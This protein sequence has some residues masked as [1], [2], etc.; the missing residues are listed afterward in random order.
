LNG[1]PTAFGV[2]VWVLPEPV[3]VASSPIDEYVRFVLPP[4]DD[5]VTVTV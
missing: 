5:R 4:F 2:S 1:P 3:N